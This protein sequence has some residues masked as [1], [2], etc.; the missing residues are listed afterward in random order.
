[1]IEKPKSSHVTCSP[2]EFRK[3]YVYLANEKS[4]RCYGQTYSLFLVVMLLREAAVT[5]EVIECPMS[6]DMSVKFDS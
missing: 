1:M 2:I 6:W 3:E 5:T 4:V